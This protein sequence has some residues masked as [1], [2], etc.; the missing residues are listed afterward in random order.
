MGK[1]AQKGFLYA[2]CSDGF[3]TMTKKPSK[4]KVVKDAQFIDLSVKIWDI[5]VDEG[6]YTFKFILSVDGS[7]YDSG[8]ISGDYENGETPQQFKETLRDGWA[9]DLVMQHVFA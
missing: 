3:L 2:W 4:K 1:I 6:Y 5:A 8:N 9:L 7:P